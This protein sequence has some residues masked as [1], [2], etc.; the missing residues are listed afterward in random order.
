MKGE[1]RFVKVFLYRLQR[2]V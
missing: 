2:W 1:I